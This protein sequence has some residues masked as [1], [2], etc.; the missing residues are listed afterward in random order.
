MGTK[1]L[2]M[3]RKPFVGISAFTVVLLSMPIGHAVMVLMEIILGETYKYPAATGVGLAGVFLLFVG[4]GQRGGIHATWL[5]FLAGLLIWTGWVEFSYV[6][7]AHRL[8]IADLERSGIIITQAEYLLMPSSVG[9]LLATS[10]YFFFRGETR[11]HFFRWFHRNLKM[12]MGKVSER[13]YR[14][15]AVITAIETVYVT[16]VFY[17][18]LLLLYDDGIAG[19]RHPV[20]FISFALLLAWSLHLL[21]RLLK[22]RKMADAVRY[23]IPTVIIFWSSIEILGRWDFF[24]EIWIR[25]LEYSFEMSLILGVLVAVS[26]LS[27]FTPTGD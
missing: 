12:T 22:F 21:N 14:N 26:A 27:Y 13:G 15:L 8:G 5:G 2:M 16:W 3:N 11:C 23:A 1:M 17:I 6:Y 25:P 7:F 4:T 19:D 9:V 10:L 24:E 20:T 18:V